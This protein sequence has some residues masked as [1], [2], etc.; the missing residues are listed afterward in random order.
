M[1]FIEIICFM[2]I[3][4]FTGIAAGLLGI[5]GGLIIVPFS[6]IVFEMLGTN[7]SINIPYAHQAHVAIATSLATIIFTASSS[8]YSQQKK[9]AIVWPF[10]GLLL[11]GIILGAFL[12]A[13]IATY[14]PRAPLLIFFASFILM[15]SLKMWFSWSPHTRRPFPGWLGM[16]FVAVTI[17]SISS[18]VG[19]GGGTM[20]VPFLNRGE[21]S[22]QKAVAI[23]SALGL[24]IALSGSLGFLWSSLHNPLFQSTPHEVGSTDIQSLFLGYIYLP[25]FFSIISLSMLTARYGVHLSHSLSKQ[26]LSKVFSLLL[27]LLSIKL[28]FSSDIWSLLN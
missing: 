10:F 1:L 24:P 7:N 4:A 28:Y 22:I 5:G 18:L 21:V 27:L 12:G 2:S 6:L 14:I 19:I 17:G 11:P 16:N 23:S 25:A 20:T 26:I 13:W 8:I 3:G 9:K 15:V